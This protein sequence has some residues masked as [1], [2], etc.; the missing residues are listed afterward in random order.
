MTAISKYACWVFEVC[1]GFFPWKK[2]RENDIF[3]FGRTRQTERRTAA[4]F[5]IRQIHFSRARPTKIRRPF[6]K[7]E[8]SR[9][10]KKEFNFIF[11][12]VLFF[13]PD[14]IARIFLTSI[15][16]K[17]EQTKRNLWFL[18][19]LYQFFFSFFAN[20]NQKRIFFE[21]LRK[22]RKKKNKQKNKCENCVKKRLEKSAKSVFFFGSIK[23]LIDF[24]IFYWN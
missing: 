16:S 8:R 13:C 12:L 19:K 2:E 17:K 15:K 3:Y 5:F 11:Y 22:K 23:K 18:C 9:R 24:S 6:P 1:F 7:I 20:K 10:K 14:L 4:R 21:K